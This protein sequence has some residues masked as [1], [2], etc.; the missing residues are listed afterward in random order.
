MEEEACEGEVGPGAG[1]DRGGEEDSGAESIEAAVV[2]ADGEEEDWR[3]WIRRRR[4]KEEEQQKVEGL[5]GERG[6]VQQQMMAVSGVVG[7]LKKEGEGQ[8]EV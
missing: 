3:N 1:G 4:V 8:G 7:E 2:H 5:I 6:R